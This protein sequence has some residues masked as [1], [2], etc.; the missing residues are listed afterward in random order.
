[1]L[2]KS[3]AESITWCLEKSDAVHAAMWSHG[4]LTSLSERPDGSYRHVHQAKATLDELR[5]GVVK[6]WR[7]RA[8]FGAPV[9]E[10]CERDVEDE[11][12]VREMLL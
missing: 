7:D 12:E 3:E 2:T 8:M 5:D 10:H 6:P 11:Y 4:C 9:C 1:M